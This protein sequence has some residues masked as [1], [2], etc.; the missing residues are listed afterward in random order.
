MYRSRRKAMNAWWLRQFLN[1]YP[2]FI[3]A[4][5]HVTRISGDFR[6]IDVRMKLRWR[7]RNY[8]GT[9]FGGSLYS[10]TDPFYMLMLIRNLGKD[11]IVWDQAA[12]IQFRKPGTGTV[13]ARFRLT[14]EMLADVLAHVSGNE[15]Y[16]PVWE[17]RVEDEAG[18]EVARVAKTLYIRKKPRESGS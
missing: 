11:Y 6:E 10:M 2:P 3:G 18:T 17:V 1:L 9:Q 5:I 8:V 16:R 14:E 4:G 7:N 15:P 13:W 12:S